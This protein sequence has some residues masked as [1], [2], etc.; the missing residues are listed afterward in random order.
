MN[1]G[2]IA[3]ALAFTAALVVGVVPASA[4]CHHREATPAITI[5]SP[6]GFGFCCTHPST[7]S[8]SVTNV[9]TGATGKLTVTIAGPGA[10]NFAVHK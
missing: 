9:G 4:K 3:V 8:V 10:E 5:A 7:H 2:L 6:D 1:R